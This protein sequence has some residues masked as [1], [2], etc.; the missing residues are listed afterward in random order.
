MLS[1]L[2]MPI[3]LEN[4]NKAKKK[5]SERRQDWLKARAESKVLLKIM[6]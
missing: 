2:K 4:V 6:K 5:I 3:Y 1:K